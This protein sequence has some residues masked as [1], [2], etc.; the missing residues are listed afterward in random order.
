M[1]KFKAPL[2]P[3]AVIQ[4]LSLA[5]TKKGQE[6]V[7]TDAWESDSEEFFVGLQLAVDPT[8]QFNLKTVPEIE[9]IDDGAQGTFGFADFV[10]LAQ[11]IA[12]NEMEPDAVKEALVTAACT[13]NVSEWNLWY[14]KILLKTL[15]GSLPLDVILGTLSRLTSH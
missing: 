8:V 5:K 9:D 14:R 7:I 4:K 11:N 13:A 1:P 12:K 10:A 15:H 3:L 6:K 2:K